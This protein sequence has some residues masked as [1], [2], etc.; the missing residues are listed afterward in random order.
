MQATDELSF[1]EV[2]INRVGPEEVS[3]FRTGW[4]MSGLG[5]DDGH[6]GLERYTQRKTVYID[7]SGR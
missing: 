6:Y 3:G 2:Y 4:K 1:G 5:G 7:Y